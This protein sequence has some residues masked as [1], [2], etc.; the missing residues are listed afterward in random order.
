MKISFVISIISSVFFI[1]CQTPERGDYRLP[2][3]ETEV[4]TEAEPI[5]EANIEKEAQKLD[6]PAFLYYRAY[7]EG[8]IAEPATEIELTEAELVKEEFVV[9]RR[10]CEGPD[11]S[12]QVETTKAVF[13]NEILAIAKNNAEKR[14][15]F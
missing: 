3:D 4:L 6:G 11:Q 5:E 10:Y 15:G 13:S 12:C 7:H 8:N 1:A 14:A 2:L 9:C